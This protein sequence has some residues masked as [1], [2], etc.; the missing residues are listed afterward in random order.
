MAMGYKTAIFFVLSCFR[1]ERG[2]EEEPCGDRQG[3]KHLGQ[4]SGTET[5]WRLSRS[6]AHVGQGGEHAQGLEQCLGW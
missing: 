2:G 5:A 4:R 6:G 3:D 1:Q